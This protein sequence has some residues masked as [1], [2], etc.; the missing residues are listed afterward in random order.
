MRICWAVQS[1]KLAAILVATLAGIAGSGS[2]AVADD[3]KTAPTAQSV[4]PALDLQIGI[5]INWLNL[6]SWGSRRPD[7]F[8]SGDSRVTDD[9]LNLGVS[10]D[11]PLGQIGSQ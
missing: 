6:P 4:D 11:L 8:G 5:G 2:I 3:I 10:L 1:Y 7:F 9:G